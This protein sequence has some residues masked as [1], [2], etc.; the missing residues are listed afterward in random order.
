MVTR[1]AV[2][3]AGGMGSWFA[4]YFKSRG[5]SLTVSDRDRRKAQR[6][7]SRIRARYTS[8]NVEAAR[9]SDIVILATPANVV[10]DTVKQILPAL[11]RNALLLDIC[12]VKSAV[13]PALRLAE[14]RGVRVASI[15]PMFGPLARGVRKKLIIIIRTG[16]DRRGM[17]T[18]ERL[19]DGA[20]VLSAEPDAHDRQMALTLALPH[21]LNMVFAMVISKRRSFAEIRKFAGRTFNLQMLLAETVASEPETTADI[22]IMNKEFAIILQGLQRDIRSLYQIVKRGDRAELVGRYE[23]IRQRLSVDPKFDAARRTFEKVCETSSAISGR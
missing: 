7:A 17:K 9:G 8:S 6:L 14:R 11:R 10:S 2:I 16:K 22:Q 12:A 21:F 19:F 1:V 5:H 18:V 4:R 23:R 3:G 20:R 15:H 13:I